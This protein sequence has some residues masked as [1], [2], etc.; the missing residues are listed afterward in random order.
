MQDLWAPLGAERTM[1]SEVSLH[2]RIDG[3]RHVPAKRGKLPPEVLLT[4]SII[5]PFTPLQAPALLNTKYP[6]VP[7]DAS[8][9]CQF[10][11]CKLHPAF[12][13]CM[14]T[15]SIV[16]R[17]KQDSEKL[18]E[19]QGRLHGEGMSEANN[20]VDLHKVESVFCRPVRD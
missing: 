8:L 3:R 13:T 20:A 5:G 11:T 14:H 19:L 17:A 18:V 9:S 12:K 7:H 4:S 6:I 15:A 1:R 16:K 2:I 10:D